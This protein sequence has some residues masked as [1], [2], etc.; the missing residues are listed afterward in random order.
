MG[1][2]VQGLFTIIRD[3]RNSLNQQL[4]SK[5]SISILLDN[6][7]KNVTSVQAKRGPPALPGDERPLLQLPEG[8]PLQR[9]GEYFA[10]CKDDLDDDILSHL[11][12]GALR[13][14][15]FPNQI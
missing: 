10:D 12:Y 15:G 5:Q 13:L 8:V 4:S 6:R 2:F 3:S 11:M 1:S 14:K 7:L 9:G